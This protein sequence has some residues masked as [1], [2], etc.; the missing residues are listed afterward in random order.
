VQLYFSLHYAR[1][2]VFPRFNDSLNIAVVVKLGLDGSPPFGPIL[3]SSGILKV[4]TE[5]WASTLFQKAKNLLVLKIRCALNGC[6][7]K[8]IAIFQSEFFQKRLPQF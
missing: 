2:V 6:Q 8:A 1:S 4:V 3:F 7:Q 5:F